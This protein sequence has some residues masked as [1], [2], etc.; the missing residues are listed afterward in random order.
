MFIEIWAEEYHSKVT[1]CRARKVWQGE[2]ENFEDAV[3]Q[4][5]RD[6]IARMGHPVAYKVTPRDF[7]T[8]E[9]YDNRKSDWKMTGMD[10]FEKENDVHNAVVQ[11]SSGRANDQSLK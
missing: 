10:L 9:D 2:A 8:K 5:N 6:A 11:K 3:A 4:F 1:E 7:P